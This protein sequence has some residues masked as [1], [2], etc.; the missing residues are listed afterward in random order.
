MNR[1]SK[2]YNHIFNKQTENTTSKA[3]SIYHLVSNIL[4]LYG[5]YLLCRVIFLVE[6]WNLYAS[7]W[8]NIS[9][10]NLFVGG[11]RFDT[12]AI[13][14]TN[15]LY[16][17]L[18]LLPLPFTQKKWWQNMCKYLFLITNSIA[19]CLNLIDTV[20]SQYSGRRTTSSFFQEF[21]NE[22]NLG[23]I[24]GIELLNHWYL[25]L[26]GAAMIA[27]LWWL[28]R[29][30]RIN[31]T[32]WSFRQ[33]GLGLLLYLCTGMLMIVGIR[34]GV[35]Y[36]RPIA[37]TTAG[38]YVNQPSETNIVLNTP[39][40][41]I[42]TIGKISFHN[43]EYFSTSTLDSIYNPIHYPT[44]TCLHSCQ[45][46]NVVVIILESF[47]MEY[48]GAY[49]NY[50][51]YTPFLDSLIQHSLTFQHSY[52]NG[53]KSID[54]MPSVLSSIP[55]FIEPYILT[56]SSLNDISGLANELAHIGYRTAFFHGADNGSMGFLEFSKSTGFEYY[57]G[58]N[59]Y[60]HQSAITN[61]KRFH[62][63]DDFDGEWGIFD[64]PF[65]QYMSCMIDT[66]PQPFM[67]SVFTATS[68]H[69]FPLPDQ[70][71]KTIPEGTLP[72]HRGIQYTDHAL[73][74][75][76]ASAS[77]QPWFNN[78]IFVITADHTNQS[79]YPQ[80]TTS[81]GSLLVPIIFYDPTGTLPIGMSNI[82]AQQIDIM[83]T[84]LGILGYNK[85]YIAFGKDL[86]NTPP[87]QCWAINYN[88]MYQYL[89]DNYLLQFDGTKPIA[90]YN[91]HDDPL[92]QHNLLGTQPE[93]EQSMVQHLKAIVQS[94]MQ[95]MIENKLTIE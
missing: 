85:P 67:A 39:F 48:F 51:G 65:L 46:K 89:W 83:P 32:R 47:G 38:R 35:S 82:I 21:S 70:Y 37:I 68:H 42:R 31:I 55:M 94:Y 88:G 7:G 9:I 43:P 95:R 14:Y 22:H 12:A 63:M 4:L 73:R 11:L 27:L 66:L 74:S 86:L 81:V 61:Q 25:A 6:N 28:Y 76:F 56:S 62:G 3:P 49:N 58:M 10:W 29:D 87:E 23:G 57:Y 80:Y 26:A 41:L 53:R 77:K 44:N 52:G 69:P 34:G 16:I 13:C 36:H 1:Q 75:F 19:I 93:K 5:L 20:Y 90:L 64:E 18:A 17:L 8:N 40:T 60:C 2:Q 50:K 59:E 92:Q 15:L 91:L 54:A 84:L 33:I 71:K 45:S 78:T 72:I 79:E 24:F 30:C